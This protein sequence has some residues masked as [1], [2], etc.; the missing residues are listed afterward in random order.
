[1]VSVSIYCEKIDHGART[2]ENYHAHDDVDEILLPSLALSRSRANGRNTIQ[3]SG[4]AT[5]QNVPNVCPS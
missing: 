1:M 5:R 4:N 2:T 3:A